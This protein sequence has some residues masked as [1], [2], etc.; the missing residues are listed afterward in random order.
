M[1]DVKLPF[2]LASDG[3]MVSVSRVARGLACGCVCPQ[4]R[5]ALVACKGEIMQ[6]HFRHH[7]ETS[8]CSGG[9]ARETALHRFAKQIICD[10]LYVSLPPLWDVW[11]SFSTVVNLGPMRAAKPEVWLDG[12]QPDVLAEYDVEQLAIEVFVTHRVPDAKR[13]QL[14]DRDLATLEIDLSDYRDRDLTESQLRHL[15]VRN[16]PRRWLHAPARARSAMEAET[17]KRRREEEEAE[18]YRQRARE[19]MRKEEERLAALERQQEAIRVE[20]E[21]EAESWRSQARR[22]REAFYEHRAE[23]YRKEQEEQRKRE[24]EMHEQLL[25]KQEQAR[26]A[27][28]LEIAEHYRKSGKPDLDQIVGRY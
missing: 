10:E 16:A 26:E 7:A 3:R 1:S 18:A 23:L 19:L 5:S 15:V 20:R 27:A 25:R 9:G 6:H 2:G 28:L 21:R 4:C 17:E 8:T 11:G 24:F 14:I 12:I 13:Q 22:M